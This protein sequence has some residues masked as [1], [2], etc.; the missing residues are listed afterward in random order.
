MFVSFEGLDSSGKS[1]QAALL[2]ERLKQAGQEVLL[3]R[4]P[5]GTV[6]SEKIRSILLERGHVRLRPASELLLFSAARH[7]L[8]E[9]VIAPAL[10][11]GTAVVCDRYVDSTT[12]YQG[13]GRGLDL[14]GVEA[15]NVVATGRLLPDLTLFI[16]VPF[17]EIAR[18]RSAAGAVADR[19]EASGE[20]FYRNVLRGYHALAALEPQRIVRIDGMRTKEMIAYEVWNLVQERLG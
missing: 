8:V 10:R 9:E 2:A 17:E 20:E 16:D 15:I 18:R 11:A 19:M 5:G 12:A 4:E 3:L 1:T 7:Q 6:V 14:E 13:Y